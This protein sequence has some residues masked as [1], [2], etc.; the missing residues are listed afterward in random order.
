MNAMT[1]GARSSPASAVAGSPDN[2]C[3]SP[4]ISSDT[5]NN[6]GTISAIRR[7]RNVVINQTSLQLDPLRADQ[8]VGIGREPGKLRA[9]AVEIF[10]VP[11]IDQRPVGQNALGDFRIMRHSLGGIGGLA[12]RIELA[13]EIGVAVMP[14]V[15]G[16]RRLAGDEIV[17]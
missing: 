15:E 8:A 3:C 16:R 13:V 4:K 9:H 5:K 14:G 1:A 11:Q 2:N 10:V 6:V 12:R 17:D 7:S